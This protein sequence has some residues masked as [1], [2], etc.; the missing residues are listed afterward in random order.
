MELDL[1]TKAL[2]E[3]M[4]SSYK[5]S[6]LKKVAGEISKNYL[7]N[8]KD[9]KTFILSK[10][11][12]I[13]YGIIRLPATFAAL[14]HVFERTLSLYKNSI[15]TVLDLGSGMGAVPLVLSNLYPNNDFNFTLIE[16]DNDMR[17]IGNK[18]L[19]HKNK[20]FIYIDDDIISF[21]IKA[22]YDLIIFSYSFNEFS[23]SNQENL[24]KKYLPFAKLLIIVDPGTPEC[25][26]SLMNIKCLVSPEYNIVAP[27]M[28]KNG[29]PLE[30]DWCHFVTRLSR[31]SLHRYLKDADAPYEDEKFT[32][33]AISN[34]IT[35]NDCSRLIR[36]T[37]NNTNSI[38]LKL[39]NKS[40]I[41]IKEVYKKDKSDY[42]KAKKIKIGDLY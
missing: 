4:A 8:K 30:N 41:V 7:N 13:T 33:L 3:D 11:F 9:N 36:H 2:L 24:I 23:K 38:T 14:T 25:Y 16:R 31:S 34:E 12:A 1:E 32:Y 17:E 19:T 37:L 20:N 39:C 27:C 15:K 28:Y 10:E 18:L 26:Q 35:N 5:P 42:K 29:C 6:N 40:G 21:D 22:K